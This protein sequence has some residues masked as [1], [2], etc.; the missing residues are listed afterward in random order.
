[1]PVVEVA[2]DHTGPVVMLDLVTGQP[3]REPVG[4]FGAPMTVTRLIEA[5]DTRKGGK[6]LLI[7]AGPIPGH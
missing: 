1:M 2:D 6:D 4:L 7:W 5:H 3:F